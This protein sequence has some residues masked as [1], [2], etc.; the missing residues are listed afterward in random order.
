MIL[1]FF[2]PVFFIHILFLFPYTNKFFHLYFLCSTQVYIFYNHLNF[3][4]FFII[5]SLSNIQFIILIIHIT[6]FFIFYSQFSKSF[7]STQLFFSNTHTDLRFP[8]PAPRLNIRFPFPFKTG[9]SFL[10]FLQIKLSTFNS[11]FTLFASFF[12]NHF[13]FSIFFSI[14]IFFY[15]FFHFFIS[16][17]FFLSCIPFFGFIL[18][19]F[20]KKNTFLVVLSKLIVHFS[21]Q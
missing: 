8:A 10:F 1:N 11:G 5:I 15:F 4:M 17:Q 18:A 20:N 2:I 12:S 16:Y 21:Y 3:L 13:L 14:F 9:D 6:S 19:F 7:Q